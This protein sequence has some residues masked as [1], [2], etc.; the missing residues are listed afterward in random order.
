MPYIGLGMVGC[1]TEKRS[2]KPM[3]S[4]RFIALFVAGWLAGGAAGQEPAASPASHT[5]LSRPCYALAS[6]PSKKDR[7]KPKVDSLSKD[8]ASSCLEAKGAPV[9]LQ[10]FFQSYVRQERWR[11]RGEK[12]AEDSWIFSRFL[13]KDE[14]LALVKEGRLA[15]RVKW[16]EGRAIVQVA[17]HEL[18]AGFTRVEVS[19]W[20][21]GGGEGQDRFAPPRDSWDLDSNGILEKMLIAALE[22]HLKSLHTSPAQTPED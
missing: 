3:R 13:E 2:P 14:L 18:D 12:I 5:S 21:R 11:I 4:Y 15:G 8:L 10:E 22:E 7:S 20:F 16:T 1:T 17:T 6:N 9:D 19:A